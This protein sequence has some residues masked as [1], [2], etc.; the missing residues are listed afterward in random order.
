MCVEFIEVFIRITDG[1]MHSHCL[2]ELVFRGIRAV[3]RI[4][5][6][7]SI[8]AHN[9]P[10]APS[11][12]SSPRREFLA[13]TANS[14]I[15]RD[16]WHVAW[17]HCRHF[18]SWFG[19]LMACPDL[20]LI[21]SWPFDY[22]A[23]IL[24]FLTYPEACRKFGNPAMLLRQRPTILLYRSL[25]RSP[26]WPR[27]PSLLDDTSRSNQLSCKMKN[28]NS[29]TFLENGQHRGGG[30]SL[31]GGSAALLTIIRLNFL[32][33]F[34]WKNVIYLNFYSNFNLLTM[35]IAQLENLPIVIFDKRITWTLFYYFLR[36]LASFFLIRLQFQAASC[37]LARRLVLCF[38]SIRV[39]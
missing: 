4:A 38:L 14:D 32:L 37:T 17:H 2:L 36:F 15:L 34:C 30:L 39:S 29:S 20:N 16:R 23:N 31:E 21:F 1:E 24:P 28:W 35:P 7:S 3:L 6:R 12:D 19:G 9:G 13:R 25:W 10:D 27:W 33:I 11:D 22:I 18:W 8:S 5:A 26:P